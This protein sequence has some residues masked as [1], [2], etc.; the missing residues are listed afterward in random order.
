MA[1]A[2]D[3]I[4][5]TIVAMETN[6][7]SLSFAYLKVQ[8]NLALCT[9]FHVNRMNCVESRRGVRLTPPPPPPL[10]RLR[11][12]IFSSR[13]IGQSIDTE[14]SNWQE[15][16]TRYQGFFPLRRKS[17]WIDQLWRI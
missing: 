7:T 10:S 9:K 6:S 13:L 2:F 3:I 11:L 15:E 17:S 16:K 5:L 8:M 12:T 4:Y 1:A 14:S